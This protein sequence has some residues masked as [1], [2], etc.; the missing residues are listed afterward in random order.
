MT[1]INDGKFNVFQINI[2][3]R[4]YEL[5]IYLTADCSNRI[6][7]YLLIELNIWRVI[8]SPLEVK[9]IKKYKHERIKLISKP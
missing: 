6:R 4:R 3:K 2:L 1:I 7:N 9:L 5:N 8:R